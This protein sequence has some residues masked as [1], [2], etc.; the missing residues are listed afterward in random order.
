MK[1]RKSQNANA[2]KAESELSDSNSNLSEGMSQ[3]SDSS[4]GILNFFLWIFNCLF[5][6]FAYFSLHNS[7]GPPNT[8]ASNELLTP[9]PNSRA[10]D[11]D[12]GI[13]DSV[14]TI[15]VLV[16]FFIVL[17]RVWFET[18]CVSF[19]DSLNAVLQKYSFRTRMSF[20]R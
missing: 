5:F 6:S 4:Q 15:N 20:F 16:S 1:K 18:V 9:N 11:Q 10:D 13:S 8:K 3:T 2:E 12:F 14:A 19:L 7:S 17:L